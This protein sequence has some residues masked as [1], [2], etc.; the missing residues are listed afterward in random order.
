MTTWIMIVVALALV[1]ILYLSI[2]AG[3]LDRLHH[4]VETAMASLDTQ[5]VRRTYCVI[6]LAQSGLLDPAS[7][8]VLIDQ[9]VNV[10][11]RSA[12]PLGRE[13]QESDLTAA[14]NSVLGSRDEVEEIAAD[15]VGNDLVLALAGA[16][17]RTAMSRQFYNDAVRSC[18][19]VRSTGVVRVF[20]L[21]G[22]AAMPETV[23]MDDSIAEGLRHL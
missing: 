3:R 17:H 15:P 14:I 1:L 5:L 22:T 19:A 16:V 6:D 12:S 21:A 9:A 2:T 4:R 23:E 11:D 20:R 8:M 13:Q 10:R 7:S 18:R